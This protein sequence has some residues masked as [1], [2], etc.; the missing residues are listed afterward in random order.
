MN[1]HRGQGMDIHWRDTQR[2]PSKEDYLQMISNKTGGLFRLAIKLMQAESPSNIDCVPIAT[3][4][5]LLFQISDDLLNLS[6]TTYTEKKGFCEDLT[7]GK[8]SFPVIHAIHADSS[9]SILQE[10]LK[11]RTNNLEVKKYAL[12]Y[13]EEKGSFAYTKEVIENLNA[14]LLSMITTIE[15]Q[16]GD[17]GVAGGDAIR[18]ILQLMSQ[19]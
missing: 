9:N 1:L 19:M 8:F 14:E 16:V 7:E 18:H 17:Q 6:S 4:M 2:C 13:M 12:T 15:K 3:T 5:G 11:Q 10:I